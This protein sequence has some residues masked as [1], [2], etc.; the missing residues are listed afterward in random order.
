[1]RNFESEFPW[2]MLKGDATIET[3]G[4]ISATNKHPNR[5]LP[6]WVLGIVNSGER[7][8][9]VDKYLVSVTIGGFFLLPSDVFHSGVHEDAHDVSFIHFYMNGEPIGTPTQIDSGKIMLPICGQVPKGT[10][11]FNSFHYLYDQYRTELVDNTFVN[12]QLQAILYQLSFAM[13][14][15][16]VLSTRNHKMGDALFQFILNNLTNEIT[17][18]VFEKKFGLSYRQLNI[19]FK[20]QFKTTIKQKVVELRIDHAFNLLLLGESISEAAEKSGFNDYFYFLKCF[21]KIKSFTPKE[22]KKNIFR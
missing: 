20:K 1:L 2:F 18:E 8:I 5:V 3:I 17:A 7:T 10:N 11:I 21:K 12:I 16:Q 15:A 13:Q 4:R 22:M 14:K 9:N 6:T 19:I